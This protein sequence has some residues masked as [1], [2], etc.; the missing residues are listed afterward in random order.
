MLL[1]KNNNNQYTLS[2]MSIIFQVRYHPKMCMPRTLYLKKKIATKKLYITQ[3]H[4]IN[5]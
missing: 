4:L 1:R 2:G 5:I 3:T